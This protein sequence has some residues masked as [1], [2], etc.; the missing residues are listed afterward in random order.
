MHRKKLGY[1][2]VLLY[3]NTSTGDIPF[4]EQLD[5][6]AAESDTI[7]VVR[8]LSE[9]TSPGRKGERGLLDREMVQRVIPDYAERLFYL[10]GPPRMNKSVEK[11]LKELKVSGKKI[12]QDTFTSYT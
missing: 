7:R 3:C 6:M 2:A 9:E 12:K 10:S 1:D 5:K 8:A 4:L 11:E